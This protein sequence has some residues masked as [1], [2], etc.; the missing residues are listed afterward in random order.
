[1]NKDYDDEDSDSSSGSGSIDSAKK[2][3]QGDG[4]MMSAVPKEETNIIGDQKV[5]DVEYGPLFDQKIAVDDKIFMARVC[6]QG[7]RY[8]DSVEYVI[9]LMRKKDV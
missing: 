8:D 1:M 6:E 9:E 2:R 4:S 7:L 5:V 3:A